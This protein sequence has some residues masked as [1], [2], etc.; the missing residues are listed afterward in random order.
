MLAKLVAKYSDYQLIVSVIVQAKKI[1]FLLQVWS[2]PILQPL[3]QCRVPSWASSFSSLGLAPFLAPVFWLLS[4]SRRL[5]G[6]HP[7][8]TLVRDAVGS[9]FVIF[10][11]Q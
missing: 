8:K 10:P 3:S 11:S 9:T 5:A 7:T 4:P 1:F 2:L 6:C